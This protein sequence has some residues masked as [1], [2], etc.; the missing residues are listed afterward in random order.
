MG[1]PGQKWE[2]KAGRV[3]NLS[4]SRVRPRVGAG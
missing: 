1:T 3:A 4:E 2:A